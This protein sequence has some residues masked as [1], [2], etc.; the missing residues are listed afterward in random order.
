MRF[1]VSTTTLLKL[2]KKVK[3]KTTVELFEELT[4]FD[5]REGKTYYFQ[6][7]DQ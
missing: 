7:Q 4:L 5:Y 6:E 2:L 3:G 1:I